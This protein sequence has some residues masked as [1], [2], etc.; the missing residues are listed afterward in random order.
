MNQL[1]NS[2]ASH[3]KATRVYNNYTTLSNV[4]TFAPMIAINCV[5]KTT[6]NNYK[7]SSNLK[8][9]KENQNGGM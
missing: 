4:K 7:C 2:A 9:T 6:F 8:L 3:I 5:T 1:G